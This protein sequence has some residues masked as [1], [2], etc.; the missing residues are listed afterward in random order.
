MQTV[1]T[2]QART[3]HLFA[4][5]TT[6]LN[7]RIDASVRFALDTNHRPTIE[8]FTLAPCAGDGVRLPRL[9]SMVFYR[10]TRS[11]RDSENL[12]LERRL[13]NDTQADTRPITTTVANELTSF[14]VSVLYRDQWRPLTAELAAQVRDPRAFRIACRFAGTDGPTSRTFLIERPHDVR[15]R[16]DGRR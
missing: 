13:R 15:E 2:R 10:L 1:I 11:A 12:R 14:D 3:D 9:P 4:T 7:A 16:D 8:M 6:D 5:I